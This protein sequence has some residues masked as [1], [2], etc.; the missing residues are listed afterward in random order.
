[1][2]TEKDEKVEEEAKPDPQAEYDDAWEG[3]GKGEDKGDTGEPVED[4]PPANEEGSDEG[5]EKETENAPDATPRSKEFG[6]IESMEKA[7]KD[8]QRYAAKLKNEVD[9]LQAQLR[10]QDEGR[11]TQEDVDKARKAVSDAREGYDEVKQRVYDDYPELKE[12]IDPILESNRNLNE[13]LNSQERRILSQ[14]DQAAKDRA[15]AEIKASRQ[16]FEEIVKPAVLKTHPDFEDL[17]FTIDENGKKGVA[18]EYSEWAEIQAPGLRTAAL[19]SDD[20]R[21]I[22]Y[23]IGQ[24][25]KHRA[26]TGGVTTSLKE[27]QEAKRKAILRDA[28]TI[29]GGYTPSGRARGD[30]KNSYDDGWSDADKQ[31]KNQGIT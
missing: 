29:R 1:M 15:D 2:T 14:R 31:L 9:S 17:L 16:K 8:S 12:L 7:V 26:V 30:D 24:Y 11:A 13:K 5:P 6:S 19:F 28:K 25:K 27:Q 23:A 4:N 20:P 18:P 3:D 10:A 21:D 22:S